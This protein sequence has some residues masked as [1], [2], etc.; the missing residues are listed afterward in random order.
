MN[1]F[2]FTTTPRYN[3]CGLQDVVSCV[4]QLSVAKWQFAKVF[5][6]SGKFC[7]AFGEID[8]T[9]YYP[10]YVWYV[11]CE[12]FGFGSPQN[13][14]SQ[15]N[16]ES[17]IARYR[18]SADMLFCEEVWGFIDSTYNTA[19]EAMSRLSKLTGIQFEQKTA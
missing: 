15:M 16:A 7:V 12:K 11:I 6:F 18:D 1:N 19:E 5:P 13:F 14:L 9:E 8:L 10:M 17:N 2:I 4:K 3:A